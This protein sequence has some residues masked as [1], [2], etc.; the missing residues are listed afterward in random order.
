MISSWWTSRCRWWMV[1][2]LRSEQLPMKVTIDVLSTYYTPYLVG[3]YA[4]SVVPLWLSG[5][6]AM[7]CR[8]TSTSS[9][10]M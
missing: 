8:R 4:R 6:R 9:R 7:R 3:S 5:S 2:L 1:P 10:H